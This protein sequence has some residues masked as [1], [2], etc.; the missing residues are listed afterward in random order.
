MSLKNHEI[1][2]SKMSNHQ[3][4]IKRQIQNV[5]KIPPNYKEKYFKKKKKP[6][7]NLTYRIIITEVNKINLRE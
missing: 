3:S 5:L 7:E 2:N 6:V 4:Y 1:L